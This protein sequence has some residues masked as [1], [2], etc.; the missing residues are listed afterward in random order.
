MEVDH[1]EVDNLETRFATMSLGT[2]NALSTGG[3]GRLVILRHNPPT[4]SN[5]I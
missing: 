3:V 4:H 2:A 5:P 1:H